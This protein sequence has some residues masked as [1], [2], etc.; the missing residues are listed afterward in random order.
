MTVSVSHQPQPIMVVPSGVPPGVQMALGV[1]P[2]MQD[3]APRP[4]DYGRHP[5]DPNRFSP[6]GYLN[7]MYSGLFYAVF[8]L[9]F[10]I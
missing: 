3:Y 8:Q 9:N 2:P 5:S 10:A 6:G 1:P 4:E 7:V